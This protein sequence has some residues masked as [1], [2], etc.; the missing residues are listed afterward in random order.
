MAEAHH[1]LAGVRAYAEYDWAGGEAEFKRAIEL[2][3][4]YVDVHGAYSHILMGLKRPEEALAQMERALELD[5]LNALR[6][7][8]YGMDLEMVGRYDEAI[9]QFQKALAASPELS[10]AHHVL[11]AT[12]FMKGMYD[13]SLAELRAYYGGDREMEEAL[14]QGYAQSGYRGAMRRAAD[15]MAARS[16]KNYVLPYD[17]AMLYAW[18][19]EGA[20]ALQ[21]LEKGFAVR[22]PNMNFVGVDPTFESLHKTQRFQDILRR[23]N[24]PE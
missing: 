17:V 4:N 23:M 12:F 20:Q 16:L 3:P 21:W 11:S 1:V 7:V 6:Q 18:A 9:A 15:T 5:P 19:G 13:E 8:F 22:D 24:L 10:V 14:T 2:N